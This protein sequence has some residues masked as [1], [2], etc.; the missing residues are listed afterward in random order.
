[1]SDLV[2]VYQVHTEHKLTVFCV[3]HVRE[4]TIEKARPQAIHVEEKLP[5]FVAACK[6]LCNVAWGV[7]KRTQEEVQGVTYS[8]AMPM[9]GGAFL[10]DCPGPRLL[11][12]WTSAVYCAVPERNHQVR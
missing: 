1:M 4:D 6:F 12:I 8:L 3:E 10:E 7:I 11:I 5:S 2:L 9:P